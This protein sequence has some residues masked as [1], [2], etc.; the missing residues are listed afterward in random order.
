MADVADALEDP[1]ERRTVRR[2][3]NRFTDA[4][5]LKKEETPNGY[6]NEFSVVKEL[7]PARIKL[8]DCDT[9]AAENDPGQDAQVVYYT[10]SV[11]VHSD[12]PRAGER[13]EVNEA[14]LPAPGGAAGTEVAPVPPD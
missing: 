7:R 5:F 12:E 4:G 3:L 11:R 10:W 6:A 1:P 14:Q 2:H 13:R 8:P 9:R